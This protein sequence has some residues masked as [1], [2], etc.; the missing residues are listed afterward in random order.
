LKEASNYAVLSVAV[1]VD[2]NIRNYESGI[3]KSADCPAPAT[4]QELNHGVAVVGWGEENGTSYVIVKNSWGSRWGEEGYFK[5][6][7]SNACG[8]TMEVTYP[9]F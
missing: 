5:L 2:S 4:P 1:L 9:Q 3:I 6:E 7:V 8:V